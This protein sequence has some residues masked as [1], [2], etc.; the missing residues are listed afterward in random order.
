MRNTLILLAL[1]AA[2]GGIWYGTQSFELRGLDQLQLVPRG[3]E[4]A[5]APAPVAKA[6]LPV[7]RSALRLATFNVSGL[8]ESRL[9]NARVREIVAQVLSRF[10]LVALEAV[11]AR[12]Q[13]PVVRLVELLN[14]A[15]RQY[16]YAIAPAVQTEAVEQYSAFVFDTTAVEVD[17][18]SV[19]T[20]ETIGARLV[21][22]PLVGQ[23]RA[24]GPAP[25]EAFTFRLL[26]VAV[27]AGEAQAEL[28]LVAA[29]YR[30]LRDRKQ[31]EDDLLLVGTFNADRPQMDEFERSLG[32]SSA[33]DSM[34]TTTRGT[35]IADNVV[36]QRRATAEFTGRSGVVDLLRE[37]N[38]SM[39]EA[40]EI[41]EHLPVWA[42]FSVYEGGQPGMTR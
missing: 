4:P 32:L 26:A 36:F 18:L 17:R 2:A 21:N 35:S 38:L 8:D 27:G 28:P 31:E 12:N 7:A 42:E 3:A 10:D 40:L 20:V 6:P 41:S 34:P 25:T 15:G 11:R 13:G 9:A 5:P 37:F 22:K 1:S 30:S 16:D 19:D 14:A 33:I 23:F 24:R 39:P 29:A